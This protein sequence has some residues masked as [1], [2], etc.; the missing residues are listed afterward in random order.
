MRRYRQQAVEKS[1]LEAV[2]DIAR[3]APTGMNSQTVE[4]LV[5]FD[6][7]E[8]KKLAAAVIDWMR[9]LTANGELVAGSY[10]AGPLVAAWEAGYDP[11][12]RGCPHLVVAHAKEHDHLAQSSC[13]IA[14]TT[15]ELT[16][17]P[18]GLGTCWAGFLHLA[19]RCSPQVRQ[20]LG[21]PQ[22][23]VMHGA[24]MIGYP[25]ETYHAIPPRKP[26]NVQWR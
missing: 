7:R 1:V 6:S 24:L 22:G 9:E 13:T 4:W 17:L 15:A 8:V 5:V 23:N 26:L 25:L 14:L 11:I 16:A 3:Y 2:L 10:N 12:L 20:S 18:Y 21:L 19:A